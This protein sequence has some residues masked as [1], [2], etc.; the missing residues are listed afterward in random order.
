MKLTARE[1]EVLTHL[2]KRGGQVVSREEL[3]REVWG[4]RA[5]V[6]SEAVPVAMRRLRTKIDKAN[7]KIVRGAGWL[8]ELA[9]DEPTFSFPGP[10]TYTSGYHG[11][12]QELAALE[13]AMAGPEGWVTVTGPGGA[14]KTRVVAEATASTTACVCWCELTDVTKPM[15]MLAA[16]ATATGIAPPKSVANADEVARAIAASG[17]DVL[18]LDNLEQLDPDCFDVFRG[19]ARTGLSCCVVATS[20]V[21]VGMPDERTVRLDALDQSSATAMFLDRAHQAGAPVPDEDHDA[22]AAIVEALDLMPLAIEL[23]AARSALLGTRAILR[24]LD[25]PLRLLRETRP[26]S[27]VPRHAGVEAAILWSW[28]LCTDEQKRAAIQ[29]SVFAGPF[30]LAEADEV[31]VVDSVEPL[32]LCQQLLDASLLRVAGEHPRRLAPYETVRHFIEAQHA[33]APEDWRA[34][35]WR[36]QGHVLSAATAARDRFAQTGRPDD[37]TSLGRLAIELMAVARRAADARDTE[38]VVKAALL[39]RVWHLHA[40]GFVHELQEVVAMALDALPGDQEAPPEWRARLLALRAEARQFDGDL[41]AA[42]A[43]AR[44]ALATC[45]P[46][47]PEAAAIAAL[48]LANQAFFS[49]EDPTRWYLDAAEYHR[50]LGDGASV[51]MAYVRAARGTVRGR[52]IAETEDLL[53]RARHAAP[54]GHALLEAEFLETRGMLSFAKGR[55]ELAD[56]ELREAR[57]AFAA[58]GMR[59]KPALLDCYLAEALADR[60]Q[61]DAAVTVTMR[62]EATFRRLGMVVGQCVAMHVRAVTMVAKGQ[63]KAARS[64]LRNAMAMAA[65]TGARAYAAPML[66]DIAWTHLIEGDLDAALAASEEWVRTT[67]RP[68]YKVQG[69]ADIALCHC[70]RGDVDA[71]EEAMVLARVAESVTQD[72]R[73]WLGQVEAWLCHLRGGDGAALLQRS[74][75]EGK[76]WPKV[77]LRWRYAHIAPIV[78]A[79][80]P[81]GTRGPIAYQSWSQKL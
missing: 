71:A 48:T 32:D 10:P 33:Y 34:A 62:A 27:R 54:P 8:L 18:V 66:A 77:Q 78:G 30:T 57:A 52:Q 2:A 22:V 26:G 76:A 68:A 40:R 81:P 1:V 63:S 15:V 75:R 5:G 13:R 53:G 56:Q 67:P 51:A 4:W 36:H 14:G 60:G 39:S 17:I 29:L 65:G 37:L 35:C 6:V 50:T 31:V 73:E 21:V 25:E 80:E 23:A 55:L 38:A 20:R 7:L 79:P 70:A 46:V 24:R 42:A 3:E 69:H 45:D 59:T 61:L 58:I 19:W 9:E 28:E 43:D 11:R 12:E 41:S 44:E 47:D 72:E 16:V 49:G 64:I 74:R